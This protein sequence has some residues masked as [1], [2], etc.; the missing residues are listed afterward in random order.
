MTEADRIAKLEAELAELK[1][2]VPQ[3]LP[4]SSGNYQ[5]PNYI[6]RMSMPPEAMRDLING[7][8]DAVMADLRGDV[9][10]SRSLEPIDKDVGRSRPIGNGF[11]NPIELSTPP[12]TELIDRMCEGVKFTEEEM[13]TIRAGVRKQMAEGKFF[14]K[15]VRMKL[16]LE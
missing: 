13:E 5:P 2:R 12:G 16:G 3:P 9:A 4:K 14:P 15:V 11:A 6:D 8:P 10:R 7:V 1:A